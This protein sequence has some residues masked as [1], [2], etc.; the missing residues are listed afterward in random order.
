[1]GIYR[2]ESCGAELN[3]REG[4]NSVI[5]DYCGTKQSVPTV[6]EES[7]G[8]A[9]LLRRA[10]LF[11][12]DKEWDL[13]RE[14]CEKVLDRHPENAQAYLGKLMA[15]CRVCDVDSLADCRAPFDDNKNYKKILRFG[16]AGLVKKLEEYVRGIKVRN[17]ETRLAEQYARASRHMRRAKFVHEYQEAQRE[18]E[19]LKDYKDSR[20]LAELCAQKVEKMIEDDKNRIYQSA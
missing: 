6:Q 13:A 7:P 5:C 9:P 8:T 11:L 1:M 20:E 3:V 15:D 19:K 17:E 10:Y 16:D 18:F 2:C 12:E 14:Y 4:I